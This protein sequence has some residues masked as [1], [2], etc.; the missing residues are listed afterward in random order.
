MAVEPGL[1]DKEGKYLEEVFKLDTAS[2]AL[3]E[4]AST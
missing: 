4:S 2:L 1:G 3:I